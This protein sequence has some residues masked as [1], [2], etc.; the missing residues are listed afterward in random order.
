[1]KTDTSRTKPE[2]PATG[3][4]YS[5]MERKGTRPVHK[6]F[7][8]RSLCRCGHSCHKPFCDGKHTDT[9]WLPTLK[10]GYPSTD[11]TARI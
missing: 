6:K 1:M 8:P 4:S 11:R 10:P 5:L 7:V 2:F 3:T 9:E